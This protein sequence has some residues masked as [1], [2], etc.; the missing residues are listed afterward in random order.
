MAFPKINR[1]IMISKLT[2]T[3]ANVR[4]K[5]AAVLIPKAVKQVSDKG[6]AVVDVTKRLGIP[7]G[8][9]VRLG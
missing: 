1:Q 4:T 9:F 3:I 7:E 6:H 8:V 5:Y 2:R